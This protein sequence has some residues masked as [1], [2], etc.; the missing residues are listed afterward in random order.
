MD[1]MLNN[2]TDSTWK[3]ASLDPA[4]GLG[5]LSGWFL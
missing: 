2:H 3:I 5:L 1:G 4:L